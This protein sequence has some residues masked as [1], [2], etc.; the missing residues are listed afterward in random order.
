[1]GDFRLTVSRVGRPL[2]E[3][4][5]PGNPIDSE[6]LPEF[7]LVSLTDGELL[8]DFAGN[9]PPHGLLHVLYV[10]QASPSHHQIIILPIKTI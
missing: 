6:L 10:E 4:I 3:I 8:H 9:N 7:A 1:M 2:G 5:D